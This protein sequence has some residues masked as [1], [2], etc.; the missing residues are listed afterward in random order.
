MPRI[1][2][3]AANVRT[4][5]ALSVLAWVP[6]TV[7]ACATTR[8]G[9]D[10]AVTWTAMVVIIAI[11]VAFVFA[12]IRFRISLRERRRHRE[13]WRNTGEEVVRNKVIGEE[14]TGDEG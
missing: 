8:H 5:A 6:R 11:T 2:V 13:G 14:V 9:Y 7:E 1:C 10:R 12:V 3:R 4:V